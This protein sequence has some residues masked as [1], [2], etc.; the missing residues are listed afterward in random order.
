VIKLSLSCAND[1]CG[2]E[3]AAE[4]VAWFE[5]FVNESTSGGSDRGVVESQRR[6]L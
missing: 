6:N 3:C 4:A 2:V 1:R 5:S